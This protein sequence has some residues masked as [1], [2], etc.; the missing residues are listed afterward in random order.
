MKYIKIFEA[1]KK[2][3]YVTNPILGS[4]LDEVNDMMLP[5]RD[6]GFSARIVRNYNYIYICKFTNDDTNSEFVKFKYSDIKD[7]IIFILNYLKSVGIKFDSIEVTNKIDFE[8]GATDGKTYKDISD[9]NDDMDVYK[10]KIFFN[11]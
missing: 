10:F 1:F 7:D 3:K 11:K 2:P 8:D 9:I 5:L 4:F 6:E